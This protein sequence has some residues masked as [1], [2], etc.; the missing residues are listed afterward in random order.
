MS[1]PAVPSPPTTPAGFNKECLT[2]L[3]EMNSEISLTSDKV[4]KLSDRVDTL[5][6]D[7]EQSDYQYDNWYMYEPEGQDEDS[8]QDQE[9]HISISEKR[10]IHEVEEDNDVFST[11]IKKFKKTDKVDA[12]VNQSLA[13][14]INSTFREGMPDDIYNVIKNIN[15]PENCHALKVTRVNAGVWSVLKPQKQTEDSKMRGILNAVCKVGS[16]L[17]K[18]LDEGSNIDKKMKEWG[19]TA[20]AIL[21]KA[22]IW[23]NTRRRESHTRICVYETLCP[24]PLS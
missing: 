9:D 14:M 13:D 23:I 20:L 15:R 22:N 21:G 17:A 24:H 11:F 7:Y 12:E 6:D 8:F 5:Y 18:L 16:N 3:R 1:R 2:I 10:S 19:S 4:E